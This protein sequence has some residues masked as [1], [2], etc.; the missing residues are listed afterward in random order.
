MNSKQKAAEKYCCS[1]CGVAQNGD[2]CTNAEKVMCRFRDAHLAGQE[3]GDKN[4]YERGAIAQREHELERKDCKICKYQ[5]DTY[6]A[7]RDAAIQRAARAEAECNQRDVV[8]ARLQAELEKWMVVGS[9]I[10]E[11]SLAQPIRN[12]LAETE[13]SRDGRD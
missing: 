9:L 4:G 1:R 13:A 2:S 10:K 7:E 6:L 12:V 3:L 11:N 5:C 8:I